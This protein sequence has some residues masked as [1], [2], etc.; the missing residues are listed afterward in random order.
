MASSAFTAFEL[1]DCALCDLSL[2]SNK[3]TAA[4]PGHCCFRAVDPNSGAAQVKEPVKKLKFVI[5]LVLLAI[6]SVPIG[7]SGDL[8]PILWCM[9]LWAWGTIV[10]TMALSALLL[11]SIWRSVIRCMLLRA[12]MCQQP[13]L[14]PR[15]PHLSRSDRPLSQLLV[16]AFP[17]SQH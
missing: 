17:C 6:L 11:W 8:H 1:A 2:V 4:I 10:S 16:E 12:L 9:P 5:G 7:W 14:L 13:L 15:H 3:A